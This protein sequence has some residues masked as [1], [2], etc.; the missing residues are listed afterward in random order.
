MVGAGATRAAE[1]G[2]PLILPEQ[3]L[4]SGRSLGVLAAWSRTKSGADGGVGSGFAPWHPEW[5]SGGPGCQRCAT[6][7]SWGAW[8]AGCV[9]S[10]KS[11]TSWR[12]ARLAARAVLAI[13][14]LRR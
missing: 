12:S 13:I 5:T 4:V 14:A 11:S 7:G 10:K 9:D 6:T 1:V 2:M 3:R 8:G